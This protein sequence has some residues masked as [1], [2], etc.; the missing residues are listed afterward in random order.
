MTFQKRKKKKSTPFSKRIP[1]KS[2]AKTEINEEMRLSKY[3]AH[4]G[5]ASRRAAAELIKAGKVK[6]NG[7][8][9]LEP[10]V[11]VKKGDKVFYEDTPIFPEATKVYILLN[12]PPDVITTASDE[13]ERTTVIDLI[14]EH[15]EERVYPV[16]RLD[17][18]TTGLL[19]LT[20]D[21]DLAQKLSHP[22]YEVEK[23]YQV[24][25]DRPLLIVDKE[26]ISRGIALEDGLVKVDGIDYVTGKEKNEIGIRLH[27]GKNRIIRRIF[28]SLDYKV[29]RL[30][31]VYYAGLTKK[32]ISRGRFRHL[33]AREVIMLKHFR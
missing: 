20:N 15:I 9:I 1:K 6:I 28:E 3:V 13:W 21:G 24:R 4:C 26:K 30:D 12:K 14:K 2:V 23:I 27:S 16:G 18:M 29:I 10:G 19:L 31:R 8:V 7:E 11:K 22:S 17:R 32:D 33:S 5:I 25:L